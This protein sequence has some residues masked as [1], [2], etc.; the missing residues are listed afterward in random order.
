MC[1]KP[2][3]DSPWLMLLWSD[4]DWRSLG[5]SRV[6][7]AIFCYLFSSL[8]R[9]RKNTN[10]FMLW[11]TANPR[12][13]FPT[14]MGVLY[15]EKCHHICS[16]SKHKKVSIFV[17]TRDWREQLRKNSFYYSRD[18]Q[19]WSNLSNSIPQ[20]PGGHQRPLFKIQPKVAAVRVK[21]YLTNT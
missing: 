5:V 20:C 7:K 16:N 13:L 19:S 18:P 17:T 9:C 10:F 4:H 11:D 6:I 2:S 3:T 12:P 15:S 21:Y 14:A 1:P 8:S